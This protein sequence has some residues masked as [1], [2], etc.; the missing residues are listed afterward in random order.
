MA[1]TFGRGHGG[2]AGDGI[3]NSGF[4]E[5]A[6]LSLSTGDYSCLDQ[7]LPQLMDT[8]AG[9]RIAVPIRFASLPH[10]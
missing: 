10:G 4:E 1:A 3:A 5:L 6:L 8:F 7:V 2:L 9:Q